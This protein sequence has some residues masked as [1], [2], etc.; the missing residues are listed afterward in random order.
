MKVIFI[1]DIV[2]SIGREAVEKYLPRLRRK[3]AADVVIANGENAAAGR[4][5]THKIYQQLLQVG[6]DVVTMGNHT[7]DNKDIYEFIDD[8]DYL[9]RPANFSV[10][11]PGKGMVQISKNGVT[12]SVINLH[13]RVFLPPHE[14]PFAMA[15]KLVEEARKTSPLV[16]VDFHAEVTSEKIALGWHLDGRVSAV[17]GT[18]THVQTA[19]SRIYPGGTAYITD[20]GMTGPYDEILGMKKESV[21]YKFQTNLPSRFEVP[22]EGREVLSGFFVEIDDKTGKAL[23]CER[24][25]INADYPFKG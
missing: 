7:W 5:I 24:I 13:G 16:F 1:G 19:D 8:A 18:H 10:E 17:V 23:N 9:I 15:D 11:A 4:G 25:Y 21:I 6:V 20:V 2:G 22:K 3:Y 12:L 14:D